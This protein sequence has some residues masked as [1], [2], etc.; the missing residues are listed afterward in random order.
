MDLIETSWNVK[1]ADSSVCA[2]RKYDLIETSWNVKLKA[3]PVS[4]FYMV[5]FNRNIVECKACLLHS[6][7]AASSDLIETSWNVKLFNG[8]TYTKQAAGFNRNIVEC[9]E[10]T[11]GNR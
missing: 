5:R 3:L 7:F 1:T 8:F 4:A 2:R 6:F 11:T 9:K 10:G